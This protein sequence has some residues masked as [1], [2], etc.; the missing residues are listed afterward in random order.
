MKP[1]IVAEQVLR[2]IV[3]PLVLSAEALP[4]CWIVIPTPRE[5][6]ARVAV[7]AATAE[8][9][10]VGDRTSGGRAGAEG[11]AITIAHRPTAIGDGG[12]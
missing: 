8:G 11:G 12:H 1:L 2:G 6:E 9:T 5:V 7:L 4:G 3:F 10:G